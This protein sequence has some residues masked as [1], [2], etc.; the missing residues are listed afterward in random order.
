MIA[1]RPRPRSVPSGRPGGRPVP[2]SVVPPFVPPVRVE[3][4]G[5]RGLHVAQCGRCTDSFTSSRPAE[6]DE[7]A[8]THR[9]DVELAALL[10]LVASGRAA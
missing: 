8:D 10:D 1:L 7:W 3:W 2:S 4:D 9:C 5:P 6:I